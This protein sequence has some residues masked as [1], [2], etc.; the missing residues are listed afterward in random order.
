[1][2]CMLSRMKEW[3]RKIE[4]NGTSEEW[5]NHDIN[6]AIVFPSRYVFVYIVRCK[7]TTDFNL[8]ASYIKWKHSFSRN[9]KCNE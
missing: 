1:M 3:K 7:R 8:I 5:E 6:D 9:Y 2:A 4:K